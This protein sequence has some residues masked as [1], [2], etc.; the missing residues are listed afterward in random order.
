[1][2][3]CKIKRGKNF[4]LEI[5]KNEIFS[6]Y[7]LYRKFQKFKIFNMNKKIAYQNLLVYKQN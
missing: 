3:E 6:T 5:S 1:M 2:S 4:I 7:V